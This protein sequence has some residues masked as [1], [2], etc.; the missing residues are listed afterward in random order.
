MKFKIEKLDKEILK[1]SG[2]YKSLESY[3]N[4]YKEVV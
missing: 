2:S 4:D 3:F 1:R